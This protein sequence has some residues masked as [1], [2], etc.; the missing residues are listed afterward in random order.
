MRRGLGPH[1]TGESEY[2][3]LTLRGDGFARIMI[4]NMSSSRGIRYWVDPGSSRAQVLQLYPNANNE[5]M[6]WHKWTLRWNGVDVRVYLDDAQLGPVFGFK[7]R[8]TLAI[9]D[10]Y[11]DGVRNFKG[12]WRDF[13]HK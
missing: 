1:S 3:F 12:Q 5:L 9:A 11:D 7:G 10:G 13:S 6:D 2:F 8:P 4:A